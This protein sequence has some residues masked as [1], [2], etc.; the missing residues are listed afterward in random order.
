[1]NAM[2]DAKYIAAWALALWFGIVAFFM[3]LNR[4]L[5]LEVYF[6]LG[7]I[8]LLVLVVLID[9]PYVQP[10]HMRRVKVLVAV[11]VAVFGYIVVMKIME[12]LAS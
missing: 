3:V 10:R 5:D 4:A 1:M 7:L 8:G 11:G 9:P 12:I 6:V 2:S